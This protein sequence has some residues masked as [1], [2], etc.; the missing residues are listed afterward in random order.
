MGRRANNTGSICIE[1][2]TGKFRAALSLNGK[3]VVKRF[4]TEED[5]RRWITI[6]QAD[7]YKGSFIDP[8]TVTFEEYANQFLELYCSDVRPTSYA[9]YCH[10]ISKLQPIYNIKL[11]KLSTIQL[12][13]C[14]NRIDASNNTKAKVCNFVRRMLKKAVEMEMVQKNVAEAVEPPKREK[15]KVEIF[16]DEEI[17]TIL[18]TAKNRK[19]TRNYY[20]FILTAVLT[21]MRIGEILG[22]QYKDIKDG[23]IEINSAIAQL[24]SKIVETG[25]KTDAGNRIVTVPQ[26]LTKMLL[27]HESTNA[28]PGA[29]IFRTK[30]GKP[31][32]Q[33]NVEQDWI[34]LLQRAGIPHKKFHTLR[35]THASK[36]IEQG[37]SI[38]DISH[39]LGHSNPNITVGIYGHI[40]PGKEQKMLDKVM[41]A[42]P[43]LK[44]N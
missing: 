36:L 19:G 14:I 21:G 16:T 33:T 24:Y 27:R 22:L 17:N 39:R 12:Q 20:L 23:A 41:T 35:H 44:A 31:W 1:K 18:E 7:F 13:Q 34:L 4:N 26:Q 11:Q 38:I 28:L 32:N 8:S 6:T 15:S 29:Y 5:A 43:V 3:R 25:P 10:W 2:S 9:I 37:V 40:V 30:T 42:F